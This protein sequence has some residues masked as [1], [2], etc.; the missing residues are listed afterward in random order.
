M[1]EFKVPRCKD[2]PDCP[3]GWFG[4]D[5]P[6]RV[7]AVTVERTAPALFLVTLLW[8]M[9]GDQEIV[10]CPPSLA[11]ALL[12]AARLAGAVVIL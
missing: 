2:Y 6:D 10:D 7:D 5:L 1:T 12:A 11:S 8:A 4:D 9:G 3:C